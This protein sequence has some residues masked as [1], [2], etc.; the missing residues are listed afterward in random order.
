MAVKF[1]GDQ[2]K[3]VDPKTVTFEGAT[4]TLFATLD[5]TTLTVYVTTAVTKTPGHKELT[6]NV[7]VPGKPPKIVS[8]PI[9]VF[10]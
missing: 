6:V 4:P 7:P 8:L 10:K 2:L 1:T 9:D 3:T 5:G